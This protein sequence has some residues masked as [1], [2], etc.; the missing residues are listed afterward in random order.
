VPCAELVNDIGPQLEPLGLPFLYLS[1]EALMLG[2]DVYTNVGTM[3]SGYQTFIDY[4]VTTARMVIRIV[5]LVFVI[6]V[7]PI[8]LSSALNDLS[9]SL[10]ERR[11]N[12]PKKHTQ[13]QA[14]ESM[15]KRANCGHGW[16]ITLWKGV[17]LNKGFLQAAC[18]RVALVMT[19]VVAFVDAALGFEEASVKDSTMEAEMSN[20]RH[21]LANITYVHNRT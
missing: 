18:I 7:A 11:C 17:V 13:I 9:D 21:L 10:N 12:I 1:M 15:L 5:V 4:H 8:R 16:G 3:I 14:L 6:A 2:G 19:A 20:I